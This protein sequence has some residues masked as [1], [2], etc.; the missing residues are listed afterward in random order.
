M[1]LDQSALLDLLGEL[2]LTD[3]VPQLGPLLVATVGLIAALAVKSGRRRRLD[4][5]KAAAETLVQLTEPEHQAAVKPY[6]NRQSSALSR[7][8]DPQYTWI[9]LGLLGSIAA[10]FALATLDTQS[11]GSNSEFFTVALRV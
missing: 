2:K 5:L 11:P 1:A 6:M 7:Q 4:N 10:G 8:V 9:G 3:V